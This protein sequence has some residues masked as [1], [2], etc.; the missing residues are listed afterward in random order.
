MI[1]LPQLGV[2]NCIGCQ[3]RWIARMMHSESLPSA[4]DMIR[5]Q[6]QPAPAVA[7]GGRGAKRGRGSS[8]PGPGRRSSRFKGV[9][10]CQSSGK[11]RGQCWDGAK[12]R[13]KMSS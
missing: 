2:K 12:V 1:V 4:K 5:M 7:P 6:E 13:K 10:W 11:W 8:W 3:Q 9:S